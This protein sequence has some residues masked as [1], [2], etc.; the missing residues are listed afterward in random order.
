MRRITAKIGKAIGLGPDFGLLG[1]VEQGARMLGRAV[2]KALTG[3]SPTTGL[4]NTQAKAVDLVAS[5]GSTKAAAQ[6][7]GVSHR[8]MQKWV[9]GTQEAK[10]TARGR[11]ADKLDQAQREARVKPARA[12]RLAKSAT[13]SAID[14]GGR[15]AATG[16]SALRIKATVTVSSDTRS[17]WIDI[18]P[19]IA[20]GSLDSVKDTF[21]TDGPDAA[22]EILQGVVQR[23]VQDMNVV[24][25][26]AIEF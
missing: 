26:E 20:P 21:V 9:K 6:A 1:R 8:T 17:R 15:Y 3:R 14:G 19:W 25:V 18:G 4:G 24:S 12:D 23:Y 16:G 11:N 13:G 22:G 2:E 10:N 5:T 7:A